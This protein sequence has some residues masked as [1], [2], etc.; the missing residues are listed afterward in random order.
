RI[1]CSSTSANLSTT[2]HVD[3]S[4][5]ATTK[6]RLLREEVSYSTAQDKEINIL[7]RLGYFDKQ[8]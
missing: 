3:T 5:A 6:R 1:R 8:N 7:H 4:E 2:T